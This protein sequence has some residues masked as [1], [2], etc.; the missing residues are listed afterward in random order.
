M[1]EETPLPSILEIAKRLGYSSG[2]PFYPRVPDLCAA[3]VKKRKEQL[4]NT[5]LRQ[6]LEAALASDE[7]PPPSLREIAKRLS[8]TVERLYNNYPQICHT[9]VKR[10]NSVFDT[11][12]IQ[13]ELEAAFD[14]TSLPPPTVRD[15]AQRVGFGE[16]RLRRHFPELCSQISVRYQIYRKNRGIARR[17]HIRDE[18]KRAIIQLSVEGCYPSLSKVRQLLQGEKSA[19]ADVSRAWQELLREMHIEKDE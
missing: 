15:V 13:K 4:K 6:A 8:C 5:P 16:A 14:D 11:D 18:V 9:L 2:S 7:Y 17:Q 12:S 19:F 3:I 10:H 1:S